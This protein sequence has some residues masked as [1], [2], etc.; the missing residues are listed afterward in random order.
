MAPSMTSAASDRSMPAVMTTKVWPIDRTI[1]IAAATSSAWMLAPLR[2][3]GCRMLKTM[4][5]PIR[6]TAEAQSA[7]KAGEARFATQEGRRYRRRRPRRR[8]R[9]AVGMPSLFSMSRS[10]SG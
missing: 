4:T 1:R 10:G 6:P 3:T 9:R 8:V 7:Q 5:S 2:K